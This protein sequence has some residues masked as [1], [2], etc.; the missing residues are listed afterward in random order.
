MHHFVL[1]FLSLAD[2]YLIQADFLFVDYAATDVSVGLLVYGLVDGHS[3]QLFA[4][5]KMIFDVLIVCKFF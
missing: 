2:E 5:N 1:A 4:K 3:R